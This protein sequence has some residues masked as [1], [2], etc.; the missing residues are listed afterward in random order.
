MPKTERNYF[1]ASGAE[2]REWSAKD[3]AAA[4]EIARRAAKRAEK[5]AARKAA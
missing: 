3:P 5:A 4:A 1:A 2:L